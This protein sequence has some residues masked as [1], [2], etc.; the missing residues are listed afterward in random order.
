MVDSSVILAIIKD[1]DPDKGCEERLEKAKKEGKCFITHLGFAEIYKKTFE[2]IEEHIA[3]MYG[4]CS[5]IETTEARR[6]QAILRTINSL[7][8]L[9][10]GFKLLEIRLE[11]IEKIN[12]LLTCEGLRMGSRD[13]IIL[14]V[15]ESYLNT[16]FIFIDKGIDGDSENIKKKG[17]KIKL[18]SLN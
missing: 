8:N 6:Y 1:E 17:F 14:G 5:R 3:E 10:T 13:R 4:E 15:A 2:F 16:K 18:E 11:S 12:Q 9:L 7:N